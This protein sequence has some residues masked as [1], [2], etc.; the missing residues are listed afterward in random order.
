MFAG[1]I[2]LASVGLEDFD[3]NLV[4]QSGAALLPGLNRVMAV[5]GQT[6]VWAKVKSYSI[7]LLLVFCEWE[8]HH[9][10]LCPHGT[11]SSSS[12]LFP[13]QSE[14]E[15]VI[16][17]IFCF[18]CSH[19]NLKRKH[20]ISTPMDKLF[21]S[22]LSSSEIK[23]L[24]CYTTLKS[25]GFGAIINFSEANKIHGA[26]TDPENS[27]K[28]QFS[29][30]FCLMAIMSGLICILVIYIY[31]VLLIPRWFQHNTRRVSRVHKP[32]L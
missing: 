20:W 9:S 3:S 22:I 7:S 25:H 2:K 26:L 31:A 14:Q 27:K 32:F 5:W 21:L 30:V 11:F 24:S 13:E 23:W 28:Q 16:I 15:W 18:V 19:Q 12:S 6:D 4:T 1:K 8:P 17:L 10:R 29:F